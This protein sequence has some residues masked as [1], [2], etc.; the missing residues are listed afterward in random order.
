MHVYACVCQTLKGEEGHEGD[1]G[2]GE[3]V[4]CPEQAVPA[5]VCV[6]VCVLDV[7]R[8]VRLPACLSVFII[9]YTIGGTNEE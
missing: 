2:D 6:Y 8:S 5:R 4:G 1:G 9:T 3:L 7:F